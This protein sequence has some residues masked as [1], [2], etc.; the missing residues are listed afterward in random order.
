[1]LH[2]HNPRWR[3][4]L[5]RSRP[6]SRLLLPW[7]RKS[8]RS[9]PT[10]EHTDAGGGCYYERSNLFSQEVRLLPK[11]PTPTLSVPLLRGRRRFRIMRSDAKDTPFSSSQNSGTRPDHSA[12]APLRPLTMGGGAHDG[13]DHITRTS[14]QATREATR[15][16]SKEHLHHAHTSGHAARL[17]PDRAQPFR[18]MIAARRGVESRRTMLTLAASGPSGQPLST[19]FCNPSR[20]TAPLSGHGWGSPQP[21]RP[22]AA[23]RAA[24]EGGGGSGEGGPTAARPA[25]SGWA[26]RA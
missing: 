22:R 12:W 16:E 20:P 3:C 17:V 21:P 15:R 9:Q 8:H 19:L 18:S 2:G 24:G 23:T 14:A 7:V 6:A 10:T 11:A 25:A 5:R 13:S 1:M 4:R 26:G